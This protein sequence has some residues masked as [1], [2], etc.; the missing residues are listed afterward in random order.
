[1]KT[2]FKPTGE[3]F[4]KGAALL[5]AAQDYWDEY[6]KTGNRNAVVWL[7][8]D[9]GA[10]VVFTRGEYGEQIKRLIDTFGG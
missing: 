2:E 4:D 8:G 7:Q 9:D 5:K 3:L 10:L 6:Q 1:M